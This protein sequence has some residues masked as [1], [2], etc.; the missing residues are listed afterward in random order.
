M[1]EQHHPGRQRRSDKHL[2]HA[3]VRF[4]KHYHKHLQRPLVFR[5][6]KTKLQQLRVTGLIS[7]LY[8]DF[9]IELCTRGGDNVEE[10]KLSD[11]DQAPKTDSLT[12]ENA[13]DVDAVSLA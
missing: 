1:A 8:H 4:A 7:S 13:M 5:D 9:C 10:P 2:Q 12:N 6:W 11:S 3:V